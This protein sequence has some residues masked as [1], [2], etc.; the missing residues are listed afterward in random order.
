MKR[1]PCIIPL[2]LGVLLAGCR[3]D[4]PTSVAEEHGLLSGPQEAGT[5]P[6]VDETADDDDVPRF[7][8][9]EEFVAEIDNPYLAFARG[10]IFHYE[11]QTE[12]GLETV[13]VEVTTGTKTILG[14]DATV[15]RDRGYLDGNL[16]EDTLDWF[17]QDEDGNVW[18]LGE[19]SKQIEDGQVV[20]TEGSWEA[21]V[22]GAR[23]GLIMLA[24]PETGLR[25]RQEFAPD[26]A[27][28]RAKIVALRTRVTVA[29]GT[30]RRC[31]ETKETSRLDPGSEEFKFY[32]RGVGLLLEAGS[33]DGDDDRLEL[34]AI[35]N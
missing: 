30:F 12:E 15:V 33:R 35:E 18:Y 19:D 1:T 21:G 4:Q 5:G 20:G 16:V 28:D 13:V 31:L 24:E 2:I 25:Y 3:S 7:P 23:A 32:A 11:G 34:T 26:V 22:D 17:A 6:A 29:Y 27:E 14:I 10:R 9:P 8:P